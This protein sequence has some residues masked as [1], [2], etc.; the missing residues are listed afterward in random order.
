MGQGSAAA[1]AGSAVGG[2]FIGHHNRRLTNGT[3]KATYIIRFGEVN[4]G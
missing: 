3:N 4:H 1:T 2:G